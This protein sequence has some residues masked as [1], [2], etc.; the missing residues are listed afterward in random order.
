MK[1]DAHQHFWKYDSENYAWIDDSM[2]KIQ[3]D[4]LTEDLKPILDAQ[5]RDQ[6]INDLLG[7]NEN[8]R[9]TQ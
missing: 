1:I 9:I 7:D 6:K 8:I 5:K 3:K 2:S 4:F